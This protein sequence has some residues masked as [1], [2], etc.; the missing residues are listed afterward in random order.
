MKQSDSVKQFSFVGL[1]R[2]I[3]VVLNALFYLV[4]AALLDPKTFGELNVI[5]A[6][7][8]TFSTISLLGLNLSLQVYRAKTNDEICKQ[9]I[10]LFI[11]TTTAAALILL[12][13]N[14]MAALLCIAT[15]FFAM[16]QFNL[17]GLKKYKKFMFY[18]ILKSGIYFAFSI[19]LYFIFDINGI[20]F[21]MAISNFIGSIP[22]FKNLT[23]R[24]FFGLKNYTKVLVHNFGI[25]SSINLPRV[26]DK[27]LIAPLFGLTVVGLYQFNLQFFM[28]LYVFPTILSSYLIT[29]ESTGSRHQKLSYIVVSS[30]IVISIIVIL[31]AP[32]LV[33]ILYPK[34]SEGIQSLQVIVLAIIPS[35]FGAIYGS[36]LIAKESTKIGFSAIIRIGSLLLSLAILGE[37]YGLV[38]LSL[39]VL[40]S[41]SVDAIFVFILYRKNNHISHKK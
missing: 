2:I 41:E 16:T 10:T 9:I 17:L 31:L 18:S 30:A 36:R 24:S 33:P 29:E 35:S 11:I 6:L 34:Y 3:S 27:L 8:G 37:V 14:Q 13:I 7:A 20:I 32:L 22:F 1:G 15:S 19:L 5:L 40:I 23:L 26:L 4:I 38:G 12:L 28:A 21:G 25:Q 39:A